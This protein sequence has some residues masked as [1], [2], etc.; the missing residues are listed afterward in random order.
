MLQNKI[1]QNFLVEILKTFFV[2][3]LGLSLIALTVRSVNFL[4]LIVDNGY[5]VSTYFKY[6]ILNIFGIIPKFIP[7]SF[8]LSLIIFILKHIQDSEF[9]ILWTSGVKKIDVVNLF[10]YIGVIILIFYLTFST[11]VTPLTLNKSRQLL[12]KENLNTFLPT[13]RSQQFSDTF[14]G[15]TFLVE[16][17]S[18]DEMQNIFLHD[19]GNN[20]K[21]LSSNTTNT[22]ET[23]IIAKKGIVKNKKI[24]LLNGQIIASKKNNENEIIRFDQ[25]NIDLGSLVTTTIKATKIQETS[26]LK[27][28]NCFIIK[29]NIDKYCNKNFKREILS[30]LNRRIITPFY[31]PVLS[32]I[33]SL[34]LIKSEK[35]YFNKIS[36]FIYSFIILLFTE[37]AVRYT[38]VSN[39][40]FYLFIIL[41]F[42]LLIFFYLFLSL[43]FSSELNKYE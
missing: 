28:I 36:V 11:F 17:K 4:D 40:T 15:F 18:G 6:S 41:P 23:T 30:N 9:V 42:M 24:F 13:V 7:L 37:L 35:I 21:N 22:S 38:G 32:L 39:F 1:Y 12:G 19:K 16:K 43:K 26:T 3:L 2:I 14:K 27:L 29:N 20:L 31:I 34:L 33:C 25:L 10:F 5:P 8:L